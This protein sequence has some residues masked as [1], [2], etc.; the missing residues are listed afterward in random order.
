MNAS[1]RSSRFDDM[2]TVSAFANGRSAWA[3]AVTSPAT[4]IAAN[5][6]HARSL[7]SPPSPSV[8]RASALLRRLPALLKP[9]EEIELRLEQMMLRLHGV[10]ELEI[11]L[12]PLVVTPPFLAPPAVW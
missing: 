4:S 2:P 7:I 9:F 10:A 6:S 1:M 3:E 12:A 5:E 8:D 11:R